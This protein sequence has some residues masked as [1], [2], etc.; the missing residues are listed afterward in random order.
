MCV[1]LRNRHRVVA[2]CMG[3][4]YF[5]LAGDVESSDTQN[6]LAG[7]ERAALAVER[8]AHRWRFLRCVWICV[9]AIA[10]PRLPPVTRSASRRTREAVWAGAHLCLSKL[11]IRAD[12]QQ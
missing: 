10:L 7:V 4:V 11:H 2:A 5:V 6:G 3:S 9:I 1:D 8:A 12:E